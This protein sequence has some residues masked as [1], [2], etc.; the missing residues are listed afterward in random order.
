MRCERGGEKN[1]VL[2][3]YVKIAVVSE[4]VDKNVGCISI[5]G[6]LM[7]KWSMLLVGKIQKT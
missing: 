6:H 1:V 7:Q 2:V 5:V 3:Q 4:T